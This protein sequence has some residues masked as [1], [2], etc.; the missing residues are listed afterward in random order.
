MMDIQVNVWLVVVDLVRAWLGS[1]GAPFATLTADSNRNARI[2]V[3]YEVLFVGILMD[4]NCVFVFS[5]I[6]TATLQS[7]DLDSTLLS[8]FLV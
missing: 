6:V 3:Y 5:G 2:A 7:S 1:R 8:K 4:A